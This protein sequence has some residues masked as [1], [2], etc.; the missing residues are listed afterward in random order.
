MLLFLISYIEV[1]KMNIT[2]ISFFAE[3]NNILWYYPRHHTVIR[4]VALQRNWEWLSM[5]R[6][7]ITVGF[8][9]WWLLRVFNVIFLT[10][11]LQFVNTRSRWQTM[12]SKCTDASMH[13]CLKGR[14]RHAANYLEGFTSEPVSV[15]CKYRSVK[16]SKG[17]I[18]YFVCF[19]TKAAYLDLAVDL[20][21]ED[22]ISCFQR[23][24]SW[25]GVS[26]VIWFDN[27]NNF[28]GFANLL[29]NQHQLQKMA[30]KSNVE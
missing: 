21:T 13:I 27:G 14:R 20:S 19:A 18:I 11:W 3:I 4:R 1:I 9:S 16:F 6:K 7:K 25:R 10:F 23:F 22:F 17:Y 5:P 29:F 28:V 2:G 26:R 8:L 15:K 12:F 24:V 30:A